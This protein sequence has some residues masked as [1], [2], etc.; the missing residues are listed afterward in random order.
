MSHDTDTQTI[1]SVCNTR[2]Q[3]LLFGWIE[4]K[5][6]ERVCT[7]TEILNEECFRHIY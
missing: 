7:R 3:H 5:V 2:W 4:K 6:C 1:S